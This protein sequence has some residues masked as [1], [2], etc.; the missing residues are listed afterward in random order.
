[1]SV[2]YHSHRDIRIVV[3]KKG[4]V[5]VPFSKRNNFDPTNENHI[6]ESDCL[7][8]GSVKMAKRFIDLATDDG[9]KNLSVDGFLILTN[10]VETVATFEELTGFETFPIKAQRRHQKQQIDDRNFFRSRNFN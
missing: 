8:F 10:W 9:K 6:Q 5:A 1:M 2:K 4:L 7:K 3:E